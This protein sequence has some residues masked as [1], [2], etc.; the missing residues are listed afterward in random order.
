MFRRFFKIERVLLG[1]WT[2]TNPF[3]NAIKI[4][5][6]N[7]DH[8]GTCSLTDTTKPSAPK[9][10]DLVGLKVASTAVKKEAGDYSEENLAFWRKSSKVAEAAKVAE[11]A[12][13]KKS[14]EKNRK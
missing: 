7:T 5:W 2:R 1:R 14:D 11:V 10:P 9:T 4:D 12:E 3:L 8:C 6:A 13:V